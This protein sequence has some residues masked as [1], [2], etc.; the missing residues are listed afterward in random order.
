MIRLQSLP[1]FVTFVIFCSIPRFR[2]E[3]KGKSHC[4]EFDVRPVDVTGDCNP[5]IRIWGLGDVEW[6]ESLVPSFRK[7]TVFSPEN[8]CESVLIG[9]PTGWVFR[10]QLSVYSFPDAVFRMQGAQVCLQAFI[11][12]NLD[13]QGRVLS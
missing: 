7:T 11:L 8:H 1:L 3:T 10:I 2:I 12:V 13:A 4:S 9:D 5:F 6:A